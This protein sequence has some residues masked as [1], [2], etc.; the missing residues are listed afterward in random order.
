MGALR[1]LP[2]H[3]NDWVTKRFNRGEWARSVRDPREQE[4]PV[5]R[6]FLMLWIRSQNK[7]PGGAW[8]LGWEC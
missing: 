3:G 7:S 2:D 6:S 4:A 5:V 1:E 8:R